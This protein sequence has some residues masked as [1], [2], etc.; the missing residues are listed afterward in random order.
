MSKKIHVLPDQN[1]KIGIARGQ[2][3]ITILSRKTGG[4]LAE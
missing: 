1:I 3:T 4:T 2:E